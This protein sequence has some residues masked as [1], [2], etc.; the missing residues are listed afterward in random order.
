[1]GAGLEQHADDL[2]MVQL[3]TLSRISRT[4]LH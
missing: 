4:V 1:M 3:M 2:G